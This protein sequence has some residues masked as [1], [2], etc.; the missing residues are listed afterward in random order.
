VSPARGS[1]LEVSTVIKVGPWSG[2]SLSDVTDNS[3]A[4]R[5]L[6]PIRTL[7]TRLRHFRSLSDSA[8]PWRATAFAGLLVC[9]SALAVAGCGSSTSSVATTVRSSTSTSTTQVTG[10][11]AAALAAYRGMWADMVIAS[12]SSDYQSPLLPQKATGQALSLL[13]QGLAKNQQQ[14]IVT[15]GEPVLH[16]QVTALSPQAN[17][18]QATISDCFDATHWLEYKNN[19]GL[20][21]STPG[22]R[23]STTAI[24]VDEGGVWKVSQL[25]V[26][27]AGAC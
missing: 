8:P 25:A 2:C 21:N 17:P 1:E 10:P 16:P 6:L 5:S 27:A 20:A 18:T 26:Q 14:G 13:V 4:R 9:V 12:R 24:V 7:P 19:G 11:A 23:H 22:G 15:K 3:S